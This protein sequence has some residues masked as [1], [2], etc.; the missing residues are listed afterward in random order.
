LFICLFS[1]LFH[2]D[3]LHRWSGCLWTKRQFYFFLSYPV[4]FYF[5]F[6]VLLY[7][8]LL[9]VWWK[10]AG[11]GDI[12]VLFLILV[13]IN[14][15]F[16]TFSILKDNY[17]NDSIKPIKSTGSFFFWG[18]KSE[19]CICK[20][21][22][23]PLEPH[24]Q[25]IFLCLFWRWGLAHAVLYIGSFFYRGVYL[26]IHSNYMPTMCQERSIYMSL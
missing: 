22:T 9:P 13:G 1:L 4:Y 24:L 6:F 7:Y 23:L 11:K 3:F 19:L 2:S 8:L 20:T 5:I 26:S 18:Y 16:K 12:L 17:R 25:S 14:V 10:G 21:G 15:Y